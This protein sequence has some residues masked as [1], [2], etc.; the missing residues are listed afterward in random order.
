M[1]TEEPDGYVPNLPMKQVPVMSHVEFSSTNIKKATKAM[2]KNESP[3]LDGLHPM[4]LKENGEQLAEPLKIISEI[5]FSTGQLP[6][7]WRTMTISAVF[8]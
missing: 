4:I 5:S 7:D 6:M 2:K 8:K 1:Y 3:R